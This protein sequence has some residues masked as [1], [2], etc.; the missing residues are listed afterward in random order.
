MY[1]CEVRVRVVGVQAMEI[2]RIESRRQRLPF[3]KRED[4]HHA[5]V[6]AVFIHYYFRSCISHRENNGG[7]QRVHEAALALLPFALCLHRNIAAG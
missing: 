5:R 4:R 1:G 7:C 6:I 3:I 2:R